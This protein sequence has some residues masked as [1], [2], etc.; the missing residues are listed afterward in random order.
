MTSGDVPCFKCDDG[1][2]LFLL[3]FTCIKCENYKSDSHTCAPKPM[4]GDKKWWF[5]SLLNHLFNPQWSL[6]LGKWEAGSSFSNLDGSFP[7][8][9]SEGPLSSSL[10]WFPL[11]LLAPRKTHDPHIAHRSPNNWTFSWLSL[12]INLQQWRF[13][14]R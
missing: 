3:N 7:M 12:R 5:Y 9:R 14:V 4:F 6:F 13:R 8:I 2:Y 1:Y 10:E 11:L